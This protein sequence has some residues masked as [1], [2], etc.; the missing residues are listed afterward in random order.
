MAAAL[1]CSLGAGLGGR[2]DS[3]TNST[4]GLQ[5]SEAPREIV[6][7]PVGISWASS[8]ESSGSWA[9]ARRAALPRTT[10]LPPVKGQRNNQYR[11]QLTFL[12][13]QRGSTNVWIFNSKSNACLSLDVQ[14]QRP[15]A[16][17]CFRTLRPMHACNAIRC[18][19]Y[20]HHKIVVI[21]SLAG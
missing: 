3:F 12:S 5:G 8:S 1:R 7:S 4:P 6:K 21:L 13:Q 17:S 9:I 2:G 18:T 19:I 15:I 11:P 16:R 20:P 14:A 10:A